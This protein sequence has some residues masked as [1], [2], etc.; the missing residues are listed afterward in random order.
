MISRVNGDPHRDKAHIHAS[1]LAKADFCPR[2]IFFRVSNEPITDPQA[3]PSFNM[4]TIFEE[5]HE[6]HRKWQT[7]LWEMGVLYGMWHCHGCEHEWW[8]VAPNECPSCHEYKDI[9]S[10]REIPIEVKQYR[11]IGHADGASHDGKGKVLIEVKSVGVG[12]LRFEAPSL[13][14][15]YTAGA[16]LD[17]IWKKIKRPFASH[18]IQGLIY[19]W[20][21]GDEYDE[22]VF[23][24]EFKPNQQVKEFRVR[25]SND[26]IARLLDDCKSIVQGLRSGFPPYRPDWAT[27]STG[28]KCRSCVYRST[29]WGL[30]QEDAGEEGEHT[31][32]GGGRTKVV[33]RK[34]AGA[35]KS[36]IKRAR[37][38]TKA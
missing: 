34:S 23:I 1:D 28:P 12:T 4:E 14:E 24:Y 17:S 13:Y 26:L 37:T 18:L 33:V 20:A 7:W 38:P 19:L 15:A 8:A 27:A 30:E 11:L 3:N 35:R 29:C 32:D 2:E 16:S 22:I 6:I 9:I 31:E 5:G 25:K 36:A 21:L 10:Y